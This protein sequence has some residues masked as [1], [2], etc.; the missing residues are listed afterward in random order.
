MTD[1]LQ[2]IHTKSA[3]GLETRGVSTDDMKSDT[4]GQFMSAQGTGELDL[5]SLPQHVRVVRKHD[6]IHLLEQVCTSFMLYYVSFIYH[7]SVFFILFSL[8]YQ[9]KV[10]ECHHCVASLPSFL[11]PP[12]RKFSSL[13]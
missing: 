13:W 5:K 11:Y 2:F 7:M 10:R 8:F 9:Q 1:Y 6:I 3:A 12:F 4:E